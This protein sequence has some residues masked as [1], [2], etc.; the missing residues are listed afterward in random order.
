M[1]EEDLPDDAY[2]LNDEEEEAFLLWQKEE[3]LIQDTPSLDFNESSYDSY[4]L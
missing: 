4:Q 3:G 1:P 2:V